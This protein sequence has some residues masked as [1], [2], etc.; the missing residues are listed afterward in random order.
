MSRQQK[1]YD[2]TGVMSCPQV[3]KYC[4]IFRSGEQQICVFARCKKWF[5]Y[6]YQ[7]IMLRLVG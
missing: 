6:H 3:I 7:N 2:D 4:V 1:Q 5:C